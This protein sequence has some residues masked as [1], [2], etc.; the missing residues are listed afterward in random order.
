VVAARA[1]V[2]KNVPPYAIVGGNPASL[3]RMRFDERT[4]AAL[5]D[6]VWWELPKHKIAGLIPLLQSARV[7]EFVEAVKGAR[8]PSP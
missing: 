3:I 6:S 4:V 8:S 5:L 1:V 7:R 2:T